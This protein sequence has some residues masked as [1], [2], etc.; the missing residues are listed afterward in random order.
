M[1]NIKMDDY[2]ANID[3]MAGLIPAKRGN[4]GRIYQQL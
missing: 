2:P 4:V 3:T 1:N